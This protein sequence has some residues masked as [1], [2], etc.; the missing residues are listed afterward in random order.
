MAFPLPLILRLRGRYGFA[1][2]FARRGRRP[3]K[4]PLISAVVQGG[5]R[6]A[7]RVGCNPAVLV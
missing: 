2:R 7:R 4:R 1:L 5:L 3:L 6:D